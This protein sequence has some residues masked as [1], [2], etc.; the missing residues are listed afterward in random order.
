MLENRRLSRRHVGRN[1]GLCVLAGLCAVLLCARWSRGRYHP[2]SLLAH[3]IPAPA[4]MSPDGRSQVMACSLTS[5]STDL[6][7][8][9]VI[10]VGPNAPMVVLNLKDKVIPC[11]EFKDPLGSGTVSVGA[12]STAKSRPGYTAVCHSSDG[13][14]IAV[15]PVGPKG[16]PHEIV[17]LE[18]LGSPPLAKW[19][20]H[21][22]EIDCL[23]FDDSSQRLVSRARKEITIWDTRDHTITNS[24]AVPTDLL[25]KTALVPCQQGFA[26]VYINDSTKEFGVYLVSIIDG[27]FSPVMEFGSTTGLVRSAAISSKGK[28]VA[29]F[30]GQSAETAELRIYD[31]NSGR[32]LSRLGGRR[33]Q[34]LESLVFS[35]RGS[36][37]AASF[38]DHSVSVWALDR[39]QLIATLQYFA[40]VEKSVFFLDDSTLLVGDMDNITIWKLQDISHPSQPTS[41][42]NE[43]TTPER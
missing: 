2:K 5:F 33:M 27:T 17:L 23:A 38:M 26:G 15:A 42:R 41:R 31:G 1:V 40:G 39:A 28:I 12:T 43:G 25:A 7:M 19:I 18:H 3:V 36:V 34:D 9:E 29:A 13:R 14:M 10:A 4:C 24:V 8:N 11:T 20:A 32:L 30:C 16:Q 35:P 21:E 37:L 22:R 6:Q